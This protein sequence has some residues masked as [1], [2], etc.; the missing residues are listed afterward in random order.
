MSR[1]YHLLKKFGITVAQY[2]ELLAKQGGT[3]ALCDKTAETEGRALAVDHDH[4]SGEVRGILCAYHN[5][6]VIGRHRDADLLRRMADYIENGHTGWF[7]PPK[8][9]KRKTKAGAVERRPR[10]RKVKTDGK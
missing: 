3:C 4:V 9:R 7:V 2:E 5:H 10:S 1:E 8:T 6:R